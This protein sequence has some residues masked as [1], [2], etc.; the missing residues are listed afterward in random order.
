MK[1]TDIS[2]NADTR[3]SLNIQLRSGGREV[4]N[5]LSLNSVVEEVMD[6]GCLLIHMPLY[7]GRHYSLPKDDS[8]SIHFF[9]D[10]KMYTLPVQ[11][12]E[13]I[14]RN[15]MVFAKVRQLGAIKQGQR[16]DCYR[17]PCS[18]P[19]TIMR[20]DAE[21]TEQSVMG[22][23]IDFS[24]GGMLFCSDADIEK[25]GTLILTF[26]IGRVETVKCVALRTV[27]AENG[28]YR[29]KTAVQFKCRDKTQK[30][31][32]Y[33]YI[34]KMQMEERRKQIQG[35]SPYYPPKTEQDKEGIYDSV[36]GGNESAVITHLESVSPVM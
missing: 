2:L 24:D 15:N 34:L 31:R 19:V 25:D 9:I 12:Q 32:F 21:G 17:L 4:I 27:Q 35:T 3:V 14:M 10:T 22:Q 7:R 11:F 29:Y 23:M 8:F 1:K 5:T 26:D 28:K 36:S 16:R 33:K 18:L 6:D 20:Q 30:S 13:R